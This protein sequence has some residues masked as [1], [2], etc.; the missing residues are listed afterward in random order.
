MVSRGREVLWGDRKTSALS[1]HWCCPQ[2]TWQPAWQQPCRPLQGYTSVALSVSS[3]LEPK[4]KLCVILKTTYLA[5][6]LWPK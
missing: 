3:L 5:N 1:L 2:V 6:L 4:E